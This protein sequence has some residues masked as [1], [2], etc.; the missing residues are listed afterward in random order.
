MESVMGTASW[1]PRLQAGVRDLNPGYFALVMAT[2]IV[3][4]AVGLDGAAALSGVLLGVGMVAYVLLVAAY[5]WRLARYRRE[6][7]ADLRDPRRAFA[8]FTFTAA[9]DVLAARLAGDGQIAAAGVLLVF[10]GTAWLLLSYSLPLL[11][12]GRTGA[13]PAL[14]DANGTWFLWVVGTQSIAVAVTSVHPPVPEALAALAIS[15][16]AIGVVLY[17]LIASLVAA[18]LLTYPVRPDAVGPPYWVF[19]GATAISVLAGAQIL[20]LPSTPLGAAV[21]GV[22]SGLSV[23]FWGFGTWLIPLL[24]AAGVWRHVLRRVPLSYEPGWWSIVFPV[25][26]YGVASHQLGAVLGVS[27]LV[28]LGRYEAW[29]ALAVWVA[30]AVAMAVALLWI[31]AR[32]PSA[33]P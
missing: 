30:V 28:T 20:H 32:Q 5:G 3:S 26:M 6:F 9:S 27:W 8:F 2:G 29:L 33:A 23:V 12:I 4:K 22:V 7:L 18:D 15:C 13:R 24:L 11:L 16:W 10:G 25:G 14:A 19:M 1:R 31:P 21:H 17:L